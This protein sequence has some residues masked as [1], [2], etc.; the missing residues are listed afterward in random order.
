MP[1]R[2]I[3][4]LSERV[5]QV[6]SLQLAM[7]GQPGYRPSLDTGSNAGAYPDPAYSPEDGL[8]LKRNYSFSDTRNPFAQSEFHRDRM[9]SV[10]GW[11]VNFP[12]TPG[13][14][15]RDR[16]SVAI[17]PDQQL[18]PVTYPEYSKPFWA[19]FEEP[20]PAKRQKR[21]EDDQ[22]EPLR[23]D[24]ER[25]DRYY[26]A[27]HPLFPL[28]PDADTVLGVLQTSSPL[29]QHAFTAVMDT[30]PASTSPTVNG[31]N[32]STDQG[33]PAK[34][35]TGPDVK[36]GTFDALSAFLWQQA[37]ENPAQRADDEN[38]AYLWTYVLLALQS[39][40]DMSRITNG[41]L[42]RTALIKQ[43]IDL[44]IHLKREYPTKHEHTSMVDKD[45]FLQL[46]RRAWNAVCTLAKFHALSV[47]IGDFTV[48]DV[49]VVHTDDASTMPD[50]AAF[51][52]RAS[53]LVAIVATMIQDGGEPQSRLNVISKNLVLRQHFAE[54]VGQTPN[55]HAA[56]PI[57]RRM[58][59]FLELLL[60]RSS[61]LPHPVNVLQPAV[62]LADALISSTSASAGTSP[63][64]FLD[65]HFF[66]L[67]TVTL[68]EFFTD[69]PDPDMNKL[70]EEAL[71]KLQPVIEQKAEWFH[72]DTARLAFFADNTEADR[73]SKTVVVHWTDGLLTMIEHC[74]KSGSAAQKGVGDG[75]RL[76]LDF[77]LLVSH[78]YLNALLRFRK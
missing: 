42:S 69:V 12:L 5:Q 54:I 39:D 68:L 26:D 47:G 9:P 46:L 57:V 22:V 8:S 38:L 1:C 43:S 28:L 29:V 30:L 64:S 73:A 75:S 19:D 36:F 37:Q 44:A 21:D 32:G 48:L 2:Y 14:R 16:G 67:A 55:M 49:F 40:S 70:A 4:E 13:F 56:V 66:T 31:E 41:S 74:R 18:P 24:A 52:A 45:Q 35:P 11:G 76:P 23:L 33:H 63:L 17:A 77:G 20:P 15:P 60:S 61:P 65:L 10:G 25:L 7:S 59:L 6:E 51:I 3:K 34:S 50:E 71:G 27:I 78:G 72:R 58:R 53:N 62:D